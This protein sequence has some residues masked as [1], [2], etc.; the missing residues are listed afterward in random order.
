MAESFD[1]FLPRREKASNDYIRGDAA[2]GL[3]ILHVDADFDT[4]AGVA[5]V[6]TVRADKI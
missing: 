5:D 2:W 1:D 4:I 3:T 6:H